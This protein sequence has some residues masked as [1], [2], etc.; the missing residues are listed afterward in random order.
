MVQIISEVWFFKALWKDMEPFF[1]WGFVWDNYGFTVFCW[2]LTKIILESYAMAIYNSI[3]TRITDF[4]Y[5][6]LSLRGLS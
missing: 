5:L 1:M 6:Y 3:S 4:I 2:N